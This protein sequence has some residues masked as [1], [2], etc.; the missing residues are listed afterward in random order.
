MRYTIVVTTYDNSDSLYHGSTLYHLMDNE[1]GC[2]IKDS[3]DDKEL[4]DLRSALR[5]TKNCN[6]GLISSLV[7]CK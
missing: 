7:H 6:K 2:S 3:F 1:T 5:S 4:I